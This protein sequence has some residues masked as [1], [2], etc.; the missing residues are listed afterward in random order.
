MLKLIKVSYPHI[1]NMKN[2]KIL[3][4]PALAWGIFV[5]ILSV[6]PGK[7]LPSIP[8]WSSIFSVDKIV[9]ILFYGGLTWLIL[10][11]KRKHRDGGIS[12]N[13]A[14]G[15]TLFASAYGWFLEWFQGAYC[16]DRMSDV[17][18]GI[19]NTVGALLGL[20][21]F[22]YFY[23]RKVRDKTQRSAQFIE[24]KQLL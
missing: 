8:N 14:I 13:F 9:H 2:T 7:D 15:I 12:L 4:A 16:Q 3:Y 11:G 6:L 5:F 24:K 1:N 20:L 23:Q 21:I 18:D 10:R 19:A 22:L 17:M